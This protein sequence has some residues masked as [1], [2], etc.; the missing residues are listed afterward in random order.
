MGFLTFSET[1]APM[2]VT[3]FNFTTKSIL[4]AIYRVADFAACGIPRGRHLPE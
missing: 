2:G 1:V 4:Y 3:K